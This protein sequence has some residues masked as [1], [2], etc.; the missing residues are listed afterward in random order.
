MKPLYAS[1]WLAGVPGLM[2]ILFCPLR[3]ARA[4]DYFNPA[5]LEFSSDQHNAADLHYFAREGGQ[6]PGTYHVTLLLNNRV[7]DSRDVTFVQGKDG[8][9][10]QLTAEELSAMGV[11]VK[12][13]S[14]FSHL[15]KE[16]TVDELCDFIPDASTDF[17]F[18]NQQLNLSIPQIALKVKDRDYVDPSSWDEGVSAAFVNYN[19]TGSS[20]RNESDRWNSTL[21]SLR[22]GES[23]WVHGDCVTPPPGATIWSVTGNPRRPIWNGILRH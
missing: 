4:D 18:A 5:A 8:L 20:S 2:L 7:I 6:Q 23:I 3:G 16:E 19:L 11:N 17:D 15:K 9:V 21:L 13:F 22:S 12:G 14:A 10:P 1:P